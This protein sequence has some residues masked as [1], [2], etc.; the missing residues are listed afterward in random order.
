MSMGE[1]LGGAAVWQ[2][3]RSEY[4]LERSILTTPESGVKS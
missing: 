4:I 2:D 3:G 1:N